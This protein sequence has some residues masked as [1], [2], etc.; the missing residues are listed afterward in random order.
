MIQV[1]ATTS[2]ET[3][4]GYFGIGILHAKTGFNIGTLW[5]SARIL[6][7]QFIFTIGRRYKNQPSDTTK[8]WRHIPLFHYENVA[9]FRAGLPHDCRVIGV[10]LDPRAHRISNY[11]HPERCVYLLGA[12]DHGLTREALT[13]CH[14]LVVLPGNICMNVAVAGSIVMFDRIQ[15]RVGQ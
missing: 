11:V 4:R 7:A 10:E 6:G 1:E 9:Q 12:E 14:E 5:R 13:A 3:M 2:A 15:K 8:A